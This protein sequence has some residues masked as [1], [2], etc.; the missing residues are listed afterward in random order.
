[1]AAYDNPEYNAGDA[2]DEKK[3]KTHM[4]RAVDKKP[5]VFID[6]IHQGSSFF[7]RV[8]IYFNDDKIEVP[9][10]G[11]NWHLYR[12]VNSVFA[13]D[14]VCL[15][16]YGRRLNR[17]RFSAERVT[18]GTTRPDKATAAAQ[19]LQFPTYN[20]T[21]SNLVWFGLS[22]LFPFNFQSNLTRVLYDKYVS[23]RF[24]RP[25]TTVRV[26]FH[27]RDHLTAFVDSSVMK[28]G[29]FVSD[30]AVPDD[31]KRGNN[32]K[33]ELTD[34]TIVYHS[35]FPSPAM[36]AQMLKRTTVD[37]Y[38]DVPKIQ[39]SALPDR[40]SWIQQTITIPKGSKVLVLGWV[41]SNALFY[42]A[43]VGKPLHT[44]FSYLP[45]AQKMTLSIGG[46]DGQI[47]QSGFE[48]IGLDNACLMPWASTYHSDLVRRG[49]YDAPFHSLFPKK[50]LSTGNV[51][52]KGYQQLL[53]FD[54]SDR[55]IV[56]DTELTIETTFAPGKTSPEKYFLFSISIQQFLYHQGQDNRLTFK[57]LV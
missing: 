50:D 23:N 39:I 5:N 30:T 20:S 18:K 52:Y 54:L 29:T 2:N 12:A 3:T 36:L 28:D 13:T 1:M 11:A 45:H 16:R 57:P 14:E 22:G 21:E 15:E 6:D 41:H 48:N 49:F 8:D 4:M 38:V 46:K 25:G 9:V 53:L 33:I 10:L 7:D 37:F 51:G 32:M 17:M 35:Y 44:R 27:V 24:L 47:F 43:S 26:D 19:C 40:K 55:K 34:M 42:D 56:E 31:E